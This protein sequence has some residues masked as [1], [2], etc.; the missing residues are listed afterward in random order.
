[1]RLSKNKEL[2]RIVKYLRKRAQ[3]LDS[4]WRACHRGAPGHFTSDE[5]RGMVVHSLNE[6]EIL[7]HHKAV[8]LRYMAYGLLRGW[9][10]TKSRRK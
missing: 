5:I 7:N 10:H 3:S 2:I 9:H 8:E 4:D 1:M 6:N